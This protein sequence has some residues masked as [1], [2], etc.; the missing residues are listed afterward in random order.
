MNPLTILQCI[1]IITQISTNPGDQIGVLSDRIGFDFPG[2]IIKYP[3]ERLRLYYEITPPKYY[4]FDSFNEEQIE[5]IIE[6]M[7]WTFWFKPHAK[8]P[9]IGSNITT[10]ILKLFA[11][12]Y[13][14]N[15]TFL[16]VSSGNIATSY[17]YREKSLHRI[18]TEINFIKSCTDS[19]FISSE[20]DLFPIK[21]P[22]EWNKSKIRVT[23]RR[24]DIFSKCIHCKTRYKG[25]ESEIFI[26]IFDYLKIGIQVV[27]FDERELNYAADLTFGLQ[28]DRPRSKNPTYPYRHEH[29]A[30][31][32]PVAS[33]IPRWKYVF[34]IFQKNVYI[35]LVI[36]ILA[37][38]AVWSFKIYKY[39]GRKPIKSFFGILS[40]P[41]ILFLGQSTR[42]Y[43]KS[44]RHKILVC[45]IIFLATM[46]NFFFGTRL[47]YLLN[48]KNYESQINSIQKIRDNNFHIASTS[49]NLHYWAYFTPEMR[50]YPRHLFT[51]CI[52]NVTSCIQRAIERKNIAIVGFDREVRNEEIKLYNQLLLEPISVH[53][54]ENLQGIF[55]KGYPLFDQTNR[56]LQYLFQ[57][58]IIK[59]I[60]EKYDKL[61]RINDEY[62]SMKS[63]SLAHMVLPVSIWT[64]GILLSVIVFCYEQMKF[65]YAGPKN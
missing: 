48:G 55:S 5:N 42:F 28:V 17:P 31:F 50:G 15:V 11:K 37:I 63:L 60:A 35:A 44:L 47:I 21:I 19:L 27:P 3:F 8:F 9:I 30:W 46:M 2:I 26:V 20:K 38:S 62:F 34:T 13:I 49:R 22:N 16:D 18:D 43:S 57:S 53:Q 32:V 39:T 56:M 52:E 10:E 54:N 64:V 1:N 65:K 24:K 45:C 40:S 41:F 14:V 23:F 61:L 29:I 36:T 33:E 4:I 51:Y 58:G 7:R 59:N 12:Y 25:I 6:T